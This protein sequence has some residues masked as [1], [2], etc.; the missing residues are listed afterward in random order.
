MLGAGLLEGLGD[1]VHKE[2]GVIALDLDT[3]K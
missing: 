1:G 3:H 2:G